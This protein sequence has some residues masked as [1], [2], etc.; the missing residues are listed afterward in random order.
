MA[1]FRL[2]GSLTL[3]LQWKREADHFK[4]PIQASKSEIAAIG[5]MEGKTTLYNATIKSA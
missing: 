4:A 2:N 5:E 3:T 1:R